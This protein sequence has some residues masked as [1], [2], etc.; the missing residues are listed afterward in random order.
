MDINIINHELS[1]EEIVLIF[2]IL[3]T[4]LFCGT[5]FTIKKYVHLKFLLHR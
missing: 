1:T 3:Q 4:V 2:S 5:F